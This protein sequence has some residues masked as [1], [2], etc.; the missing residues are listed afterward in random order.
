MTLNK[1]NDYQRKIAKRIHHDI[2]KKVDIQHVDIFLCGGASTK[3][4][5]SIRDS[6]RPLLS[7]GKNIRVLYPEDLFIE[8]MNLNREANLLEL[9][10]FLA[11]NADLI[12]I[13]AESAGSLVELGAF[14][15]NKSTFDKV[16]AI[17][18]KKR[19]KDKSFIMLGPVKMIQK[20]NK[21]N[22]IFYQHHKE[23]KNSKD[24]FDKLAKDIRTR[25]GQVRRSKKLNSDM[26]E[27]S[28]NTIVGIYHFMPLLL[29]F[30]KSL[31]FET[32]ED[33]LKFIYE[34]E[35]LNTTELKTVMMTGIKLLY[36]EKLIYKQKING[37]AHYILT[38]K[39]YDST[40]KIINNIKV[41][42]KSKLCDSIRFDIMSNKYYGKPHSL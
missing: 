22:V 39:G 5:V 36:K 1:D 2:Y 15:N 11:D 42:Q 20:A 32:L 13:I 37:I 21:N 41:T 30:F 34:E 4:K 17:I 3:K 28:I 9:E 27:K 14:V 16:V 7:K 6:I 12:C 19:A 40:V 18:D 8:I 24:M 10:K 31:D 25:C 23:D 38:R 26:Y 33:F 29:Y 35:S